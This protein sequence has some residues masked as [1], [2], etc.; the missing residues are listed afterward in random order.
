M[1]IF[2]N[3]SS[4]DLKYLVF[5]ENEDISE[6]KEDSFESSEYNDN[7]RT[8]TSVLNTKRVKLDYQGF[9]KHLR[10]A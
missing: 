10:F 2:I 8:S 7:K 6:E 3:I 4:D 5:Y 9:T 1:S